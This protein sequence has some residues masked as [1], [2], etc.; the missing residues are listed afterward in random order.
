M[1]KKIIFSGL[2]PSGVITLGNYI[3]AM[4]NFPTYQDDYDCR[5]CVVDLHAITVKQDPAMLREQTYQLIAQLIASGLSP[6]KNILFVQSHVA[7][8]TQLAW[9]LNCFTMYG[10]LSRMTQ[11]KD[12]SAKHADNINAG[13]FDYPVLMAADIIVH[14][15]HLVPVGE[16]QRQ[17]VELARNI[18]VRFNNTHPG[19]FN[20]P[21][22]QTPKVGAKVM[23]LT[24]PTKKMSKSDPNPKSYI[25]VMDKPEVIVKKIK[26][27][28]TDSIG[29]IKSEEGRD[30]INNLITLYSVASG[31]S[32]AEIEAK[33][34]GQ[35]YGV[36][37]G[38]VAEAI[39]ELLRPVREESEKLLAD[40]AYLDAVCKDGAQR[41]AAAVN[42][43]IEE[44][45][46]KLGFIKNLSL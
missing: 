17:H 13:L 18:A 33:Y 29:S 11:F 19:T 14:N 41:A 32:I 40:R 39:V 34:D 8:H 30:G 38:D 26:S 46:E 21:E 25:L 23:S 7:A 5:Y 12:K 35:G 1:D 3:G 6:E 9:I 2:Q 20:V 42:P 44:V 24:E 36:F 31:M 16:D 27:A 28:V 15:A 22:C 45:Y 10:E 43:K 37:K 4:R